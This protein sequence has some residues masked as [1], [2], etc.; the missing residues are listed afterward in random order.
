[1]KAI[2][3]INGEYYKSPPVV[4]ARENQIS[5]EYGICTN[6]RDVEQISAEWDAL[7]DRSRCNRAFGCSKWYLAMPDLVP[8]DEPMVLVARR[9]GLLAE[10]MPL[11]LDRKKREAGYP[12]DYTDI[13]DIIAADNDLEVIK[14]LLQLAIS[15]TGEYDKLLLRYVLEDSNCVKAARALALRKEDDDVFTP[16]SSLDCAVLDLSRGYQEYRNTLSRNFR[17]GLN[18][19]CNKAERDSLVT[20]ELEPSDVDVHALPELFLSLHLSR[21]GAASNFYG[22]FQ[23][24]FDAVKRWMCKLFPAL[25]AEKRLRIF[26]LMKRERIVG[27]DLVM[28]GNHGFHGW[29][30]GFLPEVAPY[31]P[32]KLL[33]HSIIQQACK[34]R[35]KEYDLGCWY[36]QVQKYKGDWK[37]AIKK[38]GHLEFMAGIG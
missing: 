35:L 15:G 18:R 6:L 27:I 30:G 26:A 29:P 9:N 37:P 14:G 32:G 23:S 25:I 13:P 31:N 36:R 38:V 16:G 33:T 22:D 34:E 3:E 21:F 5:I 11:V 8:G 24:G 10:V 19:I 2:S 17:R 4:F 7:L 20:L 1:M 28:A 12:K